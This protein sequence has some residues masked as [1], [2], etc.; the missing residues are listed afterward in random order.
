MLSDSTLARPEVKNQE[1]KKNRSVRPGEYLP[2]GQGT[3]GQAGLHRRRPD[4]LAELQP[5]MRPD[6][7]VMA[8]QEF[9]MVLKTFD[10]SSVA[11][12]PA[13]EVG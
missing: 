1:D 10:A 11:R 2:K 9:E 13:I 12:T 4:L 3:R 8:A 7:V 6:E 5:P